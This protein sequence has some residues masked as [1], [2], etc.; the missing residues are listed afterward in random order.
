MLLLIVKE[1]TALEHICVSCTPK[2]LLSDRAMLVCMKRIHRIR[3][4][5]SYARASDNVPEN[6][7]D[8]VDASIGVVI[9]QHRRVRREL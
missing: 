2:Y 8:D 9:E 4:S 1:K 5:L 7:R 3:L 6:V